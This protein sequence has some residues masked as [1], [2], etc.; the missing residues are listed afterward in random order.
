MLFLKCVLDTPP[1]EKEGIYF[2]SSVNLGA[3]VIAIEV[4]CMSLLSVG[5]KRQESLVL[6]GLMLLELKQNCPTQGWSLL[7]L[8][9]ARAPICA[10][11]PSDDFSFQTF[12]Y[13]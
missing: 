3:L 13:L 8:F 5:Y 11:M 7:P 12:C 1:I 10:Y 9:P 4:T 2:L 6:L